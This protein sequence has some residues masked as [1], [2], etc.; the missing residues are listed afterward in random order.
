MTTPITAPPSEPMIC[1]N[2]S[3]FIAQATASVQLNAD[4]A[5]EGTGGAYQ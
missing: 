3:L 1:V 5:P 2:T 4:A